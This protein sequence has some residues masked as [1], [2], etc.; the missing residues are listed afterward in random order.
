MKYNI[1]IGD[2]KIAECESTKM[3][4]TSEQSTGFKQITNLNNNTMKRPSMEKAS[5]HNKLNYEQEVYI[6]HLERKIKK[7]KSEVKDKPLDLVSKPYG[8][9][10]TVKDDL[11]PLKTTA[12][13]TCDLKDVKEDAFVYSVT[14]T[15][16]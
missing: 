15:F 10:I 9:T 6:N 11:T 12:I 16:E 4:I 2:K 5:S 13:A 7:L 14:V 1:L 3:E 8:L